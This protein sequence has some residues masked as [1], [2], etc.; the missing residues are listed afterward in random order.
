MCLAFVL[1]CVHRFNGETK[2]IT[3]LGGISD[4]VPVVRFNF[5]NYFYFFWLFRLF[6]ENRTYLLGAK[7]T[8]HTNNL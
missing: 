5:S 8:K 2:Q 7:M 4:S 1:C 3:Y 6:C